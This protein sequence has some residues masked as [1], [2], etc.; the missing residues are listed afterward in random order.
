MS[1]QQIAGAFLGGIIVVAALSLILAPESQT[2]AVVNAIGT[3]MTNILRA[4][5]AYPS[6]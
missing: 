4:A 6:T 1:V 3:N 2:A 5:K